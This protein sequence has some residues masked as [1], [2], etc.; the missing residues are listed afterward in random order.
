MTNF[1]FLSKF[2]NWLGELSSRMSLVG[3]SY[4]ASGAKVAREWMKYSSA[5]VVQGLRKSV[6]FAATILVILWIGVGNVWGE[7][8]TGTVPKITSYTNKHYRWNLW[9]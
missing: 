5:R 2:K 1:N 7:T 3:V 6:R 9:L 4:D 8:Y